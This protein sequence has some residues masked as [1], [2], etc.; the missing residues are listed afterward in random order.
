MARHPVPDD[1]QPRQ[2]ARADEQPAVP[3]VQDGADVPP[4]AQVRPL[5]GEHAGRR[6][7]RLHDR[8]AAASAVAGVQVVDVADRRHRF[9]ACGSPAGGTVRRATDD[10]PACAWT[11]SSSTSRIRIRCQS[12]CG[13][14]SQAGLPDRDPAAAVPALAAHPGAAPLLDPGEELIVTLTPLQTGRGYRLQRPPAAAPSSGTSRTSGDSAEPADQQGG[15]PRVAH[16]AL[17][18]PPLTHPLGSTSGVSKEGRL[19][20]TRS[21]GEVR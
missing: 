21:G 2:A 14:P 12:T 15:R 18:H 10:P 5:P 4:A 8:P 11:A 9:G 20:L 7:V 13:A 1:E 16:G 17:G 6:P 3:L 19:G